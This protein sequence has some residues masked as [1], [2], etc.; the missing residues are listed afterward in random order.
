[1]K[2]IIELNEQSFE[3]EVMLASMPALVDFDAPWL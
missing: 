2:Y 1:M 3:L